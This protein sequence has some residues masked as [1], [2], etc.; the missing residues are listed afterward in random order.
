MTPTVAT[1][2]SPSLM[3]SHRRTSALIANRYDFEMRYVRLHP[4]ST[5]IMVMAYA[6]ALTRHKEDDDAQLERCEQ[7]PKA[8]RTAI[9]PRGDALAARDEFH[10][11]LRFAPGRL[12]EGSG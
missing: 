8:H 9:T 1:M 2:A 5:V 12:R 10:G 11:A 3:P 6:C 4:M 7:C